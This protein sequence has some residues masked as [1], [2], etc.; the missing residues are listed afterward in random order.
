MLYILAGSLQISGK[1]QAATQSDGDT[2]HTPPTML[3]NDG[4]L[5]RLTASI[6]RIMLHQDYMMSYVHSVSITRKRQ[7]RGVCTGRFQ[8]PPPRLKS[9]A[10]FW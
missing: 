1:S 2:P 4:L 7:V 9:F 10:I 5:A 6:L 8:C 3:L